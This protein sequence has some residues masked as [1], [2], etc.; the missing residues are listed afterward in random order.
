MKRA[1]RAMMKD[2]LKETLVTWSIF[3]GSFGLLVIAMAGVLGG[4]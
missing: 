3:G 4:G 2:T 1:P